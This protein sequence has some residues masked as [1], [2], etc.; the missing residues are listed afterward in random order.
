PHCASDSITP[1]HR[2]TRKRQISQ[3]VHA[4]TGPSPGRGTLD[5]IE[6]NE[7]R[8]TREA[9]ASRRLIDGMG[10]PAREAARIRAEAE[11]D[12][13]R[14]RTARSDE[15]KEAAGTIAAT[16]GLYLGHK[17]K[18]IGLQAINAAGDFD[19]AVRY[20]H[21]VTDVS[22]EDQ[23][24]LLIPQAKRIGQ[25]TKFSN[26]DIVEAQTATMQ[27]LPFKD[28]AMKAEV[29]AAIVDNAR[30]YGVLFK[31][32]MEK[33]SEGIRNFL[34]NTNKDISTPQKAV[35]EAQRGTNLIVKAAKLGG[36]SDEDAQ[37]FMKFGLPI[38]SQAGMK[39]TTAFSIFSTAR[40][41]GLKGDESGV[42]LRALTS[43]LIS[44]TREG[45]EAEI[46]AGI[47]RT[48]FQ[49]M[50]EQMS[51]EAFEKIGKGRFGVK[52]NESQRTRLSAMFRNGELI[53]KD[54]EFITQVS[55]VV[56]ESFDKVGKG[57]N[58]GKLKAQDAVKIAKL[59]R[60][61][62]RMSVESTDIEG[63]WDAHLSSQTFTPALRNK[64]YTD[65]HGGKAGMVAQHLDQF[66]EDRDELL[67]ISAT[68]TFARD[69]AMYM[70]EG[71]GGSL[72]NVKGSYE[73]VVLN[74]GTKNAPMIQGIA[75]GLAAVGD[76][77]ANLP[78][79]VVQGGT[80]LGI[81]SGTG[82]VSASALAMW[83]QLTGS[84][85][86]K[87]AG[88]STAMGTLA[89]TSVGAL[90]L[91]GYLASDTAASAV[92]NKDFATPY[93]GGGMLAAD[94]GGYGLGAAIAQADTLPGADFFSGK[95][96]A[97][98]QAATKSV[99]DL[100]AELAGVEQLITGLRASGEGAFSPDAAGLEAKKAQIEAS[101]DALQAKLKSVPGEA[102]VPRPDASGFPGANAPEINAATAVLQRYK[103]EL[104]ALKSE[105]ASQADLGPPGLGM[106]LEQRKAELERLI[107]GV[108]AQFT[109]LSS[110]TIAPQFD[111]SGAQAFGTAVDGVKA[112]AQEAAAL[113]I[114]I[115]ISAP[116]AGTLI[117]QL[118][119]IID[120]AARAE[121]AAARASRAGGGGGG[122]TLRARTTSRSFSDGVTPGYGSQ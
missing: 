98:A 99:A 30:Y 90:G 33:S 119:Q 41:S 103:A 77:I 73:T 8:R 69:K 29:G 97:P 38:A 112:K 58:K 21:A 93:L 34:Q 87:S 80:L 50:P 17:S 79:R 37:Q 59:A 81:G 96:A 84:A 109:A 121:A 72:D 48:K 101:I 100:K 85:L 12:R 107:S 118:Q 51:A 1:P 104:A 10:A 7:V 3:S 13:E 56:G 31:S 16:T 6:R 117:Q 9:D 62:H 108:Q 57:P 64:F 71:L 61:F 92:K 4:T 67:K 75:N 35:A 40:R 18:E 55:S 46:A 52:F 68:P 45:R 88:A 53:T 94:P 91:G 70:T 89:G 122:D 111:A 32:S 74:L 86:L 65:K 2:K 14:A 5:E 113:S 49:K 66:R 114:N 42:F 15:R 27:G 43:K 105:M 22:E 11:A 63:L 24:R 110:Q 28:P 20:Q 115:P 25:E 116:G 36:A 39:D 78:D 60:D 83:G 47:D 26:R 82:A 54:D 102:V 120:L 19:Y 106:G 44:P 76:G 95:V 23:Q